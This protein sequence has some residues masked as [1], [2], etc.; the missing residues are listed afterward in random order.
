MQNKKVFSVQVKKNHA[1]RSGSCVYSWYT[2]PHGSKQREPSKILH[3]YGSERQD[4][5]TL[6][7]LATTCAYPEFNF[8]YFSK[9]LWYILLQKVSSRR[10]PIC[11]AD[12]SKLAGCLLSP[13][14]RLQP[15]TRDVPTLIYSKQTYKKS[16]KDAPVGSTSYARN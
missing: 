9:T 14:P 4:V 6:I 11:V 16:N 1:S 15:H 12:D 5:F 3:I 2:G 8:G 7:F 10:S 13:Q